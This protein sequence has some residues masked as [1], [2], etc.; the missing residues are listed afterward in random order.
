MSVINEVLNQL[1]QRGVAVG[2]E[3]AVVRPV[4]VP[5][6]TSNLG[7]G[8]VIAAAVLIVLA[9]S[10][11]GR[12]HWLISNEPQPKQ[13]LLQPTTGSVDVVS[14]VM[15]TMDFVL[16]PPASRMSFELSTV[17]LEIHAR[18]ERIIVPVATSA[19]HKAQVATESIA[20]PPPEQSIHSYSPLEGARAQ[21]QEGEGRVSIP[22][23]GL[24]HD[25]Q[26]QAQVGLKQISAAQHADAEFRKAVALMQQGRIADAQAGYQAALKLDPTHEAARQAWVALLIEDKR[27]GEA[28]LILQEGLKIQP[29]QSGYAMLLARLQIQGAEI[30]AALLTLQNSLAYA[31]KNPDYLAFYAALLQRKNQ[32]QAALLHY[33]SALRLQPN[34]GVW[35]MGYGLSLQALA[36]NAEAKQALQQALSTQS[37]SPELQA[38]VQQ[39]IKGL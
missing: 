39:K 15:P 21:S 35:L 14:V 29:A 31:E 9:G 3:Q 11:V 18:Q 20:S 2:A 34:K 30:D 38:F 17:P 8:L 4:P 7:W 27:I 32:H 5:R 28:E 24:K 19:L 33:Q 12:A 37:L 23:V 25:L 22:P 36:R 1:E 26:H 13:A 16:A 10:Y 6:A